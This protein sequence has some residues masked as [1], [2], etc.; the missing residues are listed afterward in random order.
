MTINIV[1]SRSCKYKFVTKAK[2]RVRVQQKPVM[3]IRICIRAVGS[4][5]VWRD[6]NPD[7]EQIS[8]DKKLN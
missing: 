4:G 7:P 5:T 6:T 8:H 2:E 1:C 3:R